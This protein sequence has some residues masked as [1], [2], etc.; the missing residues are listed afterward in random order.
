[1]SVPKGIILDGVHY[2]KLHIAALKRNGEVLDGENAGRAKS[3]GMIRDIIGTYY[4]YT[5]TIDADEGS[6]A[7]YDAF[8]EQITAPV[9]SHTVTFPYGQGT[10]TYNA[11]VSKASDE[12]KS[13]TDTETRWGS[14]SFDF[15]AMSPYRR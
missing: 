8:Y 2:D 3:G 9:N 15:I 1:M 4:N 10:I 6:A 7:Q 12:V 5:A 14:L 11:Y 13:I